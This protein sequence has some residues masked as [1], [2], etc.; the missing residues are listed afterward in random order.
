MTGLRRGELC[1]L[2]WSNVDFRNR[3]ILV[4]RSLVRVHKDRSGSFKNLEWVGSTAFALALP[5]SKK[6]RRTIVM[7]PELENLLRQLRA[8]S[9]EASPYVFQN[10]AGGP[11]ELDE[12]VDELHAA[13]DRAGV[14]RFGL[15]GVRHF[16]AS[17]LHQAGASLAQA[18]DQ[19]GHSTIDMTDHYTHVLDSGR[20]YAE[21]VGRDFSSVITVLAEQ[22]EEGAMQQ[23]KH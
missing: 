18:R 19:L 10:G 21:I 4:E 17:A 1:G 2:L 8:I 20:E 15:H 11:L 9:S 14:K 16:F 7:P 13:Q 22:T 23:V 12:I 6:G 3:T 5:K